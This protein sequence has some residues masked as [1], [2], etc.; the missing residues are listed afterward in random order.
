MLNPPLG[1][2]NNYLRPGATG[3][4]SRPMSPPDEPPPKKLVLKAAEFTRVNETGN[5]LA[6]SGNETLDMLRINRAHE[7]KI[8]YCAVGP[9]PKKKFSRR[10]R[11]YFAILATGNLVMMAMLFIE[12]DPF[13]IACLLA[14]MALFT[15]ALSWIMFF[16]FD[17]Y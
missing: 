16:L 3:C 9:A 1:R 8:G 2:Q 14:G 15:S 13:S 7:E 11:E 4:S 17:D 6:P 5:D 12:N 10:T